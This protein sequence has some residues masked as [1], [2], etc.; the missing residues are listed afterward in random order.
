MD[1]LMFWPLVAIHVKNSD[2]AHRLNWPVPFKPTHTFR[3]WIVNSETI[4]FCLIL[5]I[6]RGLMRKIPN[7]LEEKRENYT[8]I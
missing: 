8:K 2:T 4:S 3:F 5:T 6:F 1:D 7:I